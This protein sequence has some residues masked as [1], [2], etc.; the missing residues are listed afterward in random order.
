MFWCS[1]CGATTPKS[2]HSRH[3]AAE[4]RAADRRAL[5]E[6]LMSEIRLKLESMSDGE[7]AAFNARMQGFAP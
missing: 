3:E 2:C 4:R 1:V 7:F 5:T 6:S